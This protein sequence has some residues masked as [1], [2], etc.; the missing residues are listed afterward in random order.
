M[1]TAVEMQKFSSKGSEDLHSLFLILVFLVI[2]NK[3]EN[4]M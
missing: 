4:I 1:L 3:D 2:V